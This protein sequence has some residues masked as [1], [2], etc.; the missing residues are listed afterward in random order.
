MAPSANSEAGLLSLFGG[1]P[2]K[3]FERMFNFLTQLA[4][5]EARVQHIPEEVLKA[6]KSYA[7]MGAADDG[8]ILSMQWN[9][10]AWATT[11]TPL[12]S[13]VAKKMKIQ[14]MANNPKPI[15]V[16][17][18]QEHVSLLQGS[19]AIP[20]WQSRAMKPTVSQPKRKLTPPKI[21]PKSPQISLA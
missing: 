19:Q 1:F 9:G 6:P 5:D 8:G 13:Q 20:L 2:L 16:S 18:S 4:L 21:V 11:Q 7:V 3:K 17:I 10:K 14:P 15:W 12:P